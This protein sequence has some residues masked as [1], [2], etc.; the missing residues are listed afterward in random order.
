MDYSKLTTMQLTAT[1]NAF[2]QIEM[3]LHDDLPLE[4]PSMLV[5]YISMDE[6]GRMSLRNEMSVKANFLAYAESIGNEGMADALV[7]IA[8]DMKGMSARELKSVASGGLS[9]LA[10]K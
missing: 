8:D 10:E 5:E 6:D 9:K 4:F 3:I 7:R 2:M 1:A